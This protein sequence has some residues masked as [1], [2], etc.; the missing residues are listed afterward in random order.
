MKHR[1]V[2]AAITAAIVGVTA[3]VASTTVDAKNLR[4]SSQGDVLTHDPHSQNESFNN[5]FNGHIYEQLY[6]RDKDM[7]LI[8]TLAESHKQTSPTVWVFNLRKGVKW[9]DGSDFTAD[10]VVYSIERTQH[11]NSQMRV[12]GNALGKARAIDKH[13]VELTTP[14]PNPVLLDM[15]GSGNIF[16]MSKAWA[17]KNKVTVPQNYADKEETFAVRNAM[18]TGPFM[19]VS[20]EQDVKTLLKKNPNWWGIKAGRFNGNVETVEYRPIKSAPTRMAALISGELDF[21]L[22]PPASDINKLKQ[23]KNIKIWEGRENRIIY[24]GMDQNR[25]ELLYSDV[26]GKNPFKDKRVRMAMYQAVDINAIKTSVMRG[27]SVPTAINLPNPT[28]AGIPASMDVRHKFDI[29]AA[30]KLLSEAGYPNGFGVS[31]DCPNDRYVNDERI[32]VALA[33]MWAK[34]GVNVKVNAMPKAQYFPKSEKRDT[35][36]YLFGWGGA[37]TDAIFTLKPV[38]H[39]PNDKGSGDY[40]RG[41]YKNEKMDALIQAAEGEM[42]KTK[43]QAAIIDAMKIHH[44]EVHHIPLHIQVI[45]WASRA[46]VS[47]TH[48]ADNW[49]QMSWVTIK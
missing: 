36:L 20:R 30:K 42:D 13:T 6:S 11:K 5:A 2:L 10:D 37:T 12:Y 7:K 40:N 19:L 16:I 49:L 8:P 18:G 35:S 46:G 22:D 17:E 45:P 41:S 31:M 25:D 28:G 38:L 32:C 29:A 9:Q 34:I 39:T 47:L 33:G 3:G 24:V 23:D 14:I 21:V 26:K 1:F 48:R 15:V 4:W 44:E 27:L 43:R